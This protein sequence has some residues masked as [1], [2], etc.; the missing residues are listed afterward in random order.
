M[1]PTNHGWSPAAPG[2]KPNQ[3]GATV[4][5]ANNGNEEEDRE[6]SSEEVN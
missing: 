3:T 5:E 2:D 1:V 4:S 6:E